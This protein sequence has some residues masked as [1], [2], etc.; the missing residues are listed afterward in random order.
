MVAD[1]S[2]DMEDERILVLGANS[3]LGQHIVQAIQQEAESVAAIRTYDLD[4]PFHA[5]L[6]YKTRWK[7]V[8]EAAT[9]EV[10]LR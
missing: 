2:W 9:F 6:P 7:I 10:K 4:E 1:S 8:S 5:R 3:F